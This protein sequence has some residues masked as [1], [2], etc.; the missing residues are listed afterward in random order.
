MPTL[1]FIHIFSSFLLAIHSH[2]SRSCLWKRKWVTVSYNLPSESPAQQTC[3]DPQEE[4]CHFASQL[5]M[6]VPAKLPLDAKS[7]PL[8]PLPA[9]FWL[10]FPTLED[11]GGGLCW[12][13]CVG[14]SLYFTMDIYG[15][16]IFLDSLVHT[17]TADD[18]VILIFRYNQGDWSTIVGNL[19]GWG[20]PCY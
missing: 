14:Y 18:I 3:M 10:P 9:G 8:A 11:R 12:E 4:I 6:G 13:D 1:S 19:L 16:E 7:L 20:S 17:N 2:R 5:R 15:L